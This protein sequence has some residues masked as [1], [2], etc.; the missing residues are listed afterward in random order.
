MRDGELTIPEHIPDDHEWDNDNCTCDMCLNSTFEERQELKDRY[1][2]I[3]PYFKKH[4]RITK[5]CF[6]NLNQ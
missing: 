3:F 5:E 1:F 6:G 2:N 4:D